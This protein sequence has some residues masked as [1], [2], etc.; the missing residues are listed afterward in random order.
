[1]AW[2]LSGNIR[3]AQGPQ[4]ATG[5]AGQLELVGSEFFRTATTQVVA[6]AAQNISISGPHISGST[7]RGS[8]T[9]AFV[10]SQ[11]TARTNADQ[12]LQV[13]LQFSKDNGAT[14]SFVD[15]SF[16]RNGNDPTTPLSGFQSG[17][18]FFLTSEPSRFRLLANNGSGGG[19]V[20]V[21]STQLTAH[22]FK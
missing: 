8:A 18:V 13:I 19:G 21:Y 5:P 7:V 14:W 17:W 4:G 10:K 12:N 3:G 9:K 20:S 16:T 1:M 22:Y 11:H 15:E 6:N 2:A